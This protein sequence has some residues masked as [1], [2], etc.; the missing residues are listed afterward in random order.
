[1]AISRAGNWCIKLLGNLAV[2]IK[3][4]KKHPSNGDICNS[5]N[6][7]EIKSKNF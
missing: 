7:E 3:S 4:Y 2:C 6:N 1:M 5:V